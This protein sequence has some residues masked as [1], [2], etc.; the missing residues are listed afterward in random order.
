MVAPLH[1]CYFVVVAFVCWWWWFLLYVLFVC[2]LGFVGGG[3]GG[4]LFCLK[5]KLDDARGLLLIKTF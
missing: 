5:K 4:E 1:A 3:R 2:L